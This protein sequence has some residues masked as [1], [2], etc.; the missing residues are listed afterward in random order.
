MFISSNSLRASSSFP[1]N[2]TFAN[3]IS[4]M[5]SRRHPKF[6]SVLQSLTHQLKVLLFGMFI[7][8]TNNHIQSSH[9]ITIY[10]YMK[11]IHSLQACGGIQRSPE[12]SSEK[13]N[14]EVERNEDKCKY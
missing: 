3:K 6:F 8:A 9:S 4:I 2:K 13:I 1:Q 11:E 14:K 12:M 10:T 7:L 5:K